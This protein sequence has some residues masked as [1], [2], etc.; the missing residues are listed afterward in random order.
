VLNQQNEA[1][2]MN[3]E[4]VIRQAMLD[5]NIKGIMQLCER[6]G[7]SYTDVFKMLKNNGSVKLVKVI[8]VLDYLNVKI[9][10]VNKGE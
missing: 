3:L 1:V 8:E 10:F 7:V 9:K 5:N 6:T 2:K 4:K